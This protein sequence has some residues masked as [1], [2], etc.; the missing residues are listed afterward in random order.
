MII[1]RSYLLPVVLLVG[2]LGAC[3][4]ERSESVTSPA[5]VDAPILNAT[6]NK[7]LKEIDLNINTADKTINQIDQTE[8]PSSSVAGAASEPEL[9]ADDEDDIEEDQN[10]VAERV[11]RETGELADDLNGMTDRVLGSGQR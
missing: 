10:P 9:Y 8:G 2:F 4:R 1:T 5:S 7:D 11:D 3:N 6:E